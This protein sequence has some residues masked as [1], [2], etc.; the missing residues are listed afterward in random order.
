MDSLV[1]LDVET[2]GLRP[3]QD[4]IIEIYMLKVHQSGSTEEFSKLINPGRPLPEKITE[5]TGLRDEDLRDAPTEADAAPA[6]REFL[7]DGVPV[8]HNLSFDL[9]FLNSMFRRNNL[10]PLAS[11]G[12]DTL[13]LSR[14]AF[15]KLCV[16]PGGGGSHRLA[17]L[18][19]HFG[20]DKSFSNSHRAKD[21]V[22]LLVQVYRCLQQVLSDSY[23]YDFPREVAE[24]C[25]EC[26]RAMTVEHMR[27]GRL[28]V[29]CSKCGR[30]GP[31]G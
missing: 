9:Q 6:V 13:A 7:A 23:A 20:L 2:T 1:F 3:K 26:G 18:M 16:Y 5:I 31:I 12:I 4:R 14:E 24:G 8:G 15:P 11:K 28:R 29:Y 17:N 25:Q 22:L 19:Y 10:E 21:D 27:A 30:E